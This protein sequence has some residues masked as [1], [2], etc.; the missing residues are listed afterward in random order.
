[1]SSPRY[2]SLFPSCECVLVSQSVIYITPVSAAPY[3]R[4]EPGILL[5]FCR[6]QRRTANTALHI[7]YSVRVVFHGFCV[8]SVPYRPVKGVGIVSMPARYIRRRRIVPGVTD[9][10]P[11]ASSGGFTVP[12]AGLF[13]AVRPSVCSLLRKAG[14]PRIC[15]TAAACGMFRIR[16]LVARVGAGWRCTGHAMTAKKGAGEPESRS[17]NSENVSAAPFLFPRSL[18]F[19]GLAATQHTATRRKAPH[20][21]NNAATDALSRQPNVKS[22]R[23]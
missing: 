12:A 16:P 4:S 18:R 19:S 15:L 6:I 22:Y 5:S 9:R 14:I 7:P 1:M 21:H 8:S 23:P 11:Q 10:H 13:P 20:G 2:K 3:A 17:G